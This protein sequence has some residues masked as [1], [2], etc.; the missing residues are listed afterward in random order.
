MYK[1]FMYEA[2]NAAPVGYAIEAILTQSDMDQLMNGGK[3]IKT[4]AAWKNIENETISIKIK[5]LTIQVGADTQTMV[6]NDEVTLTI[7]QEMANSVVTN[8]KTGGTVS[9]AITGITVNFIK[10]ND[11]IQIKKQNESQMTKLLTFNQFVNEA[12]G[13]NWIVDVVGD[14]KKG[15]LKKEMGGKVTAEKIAKSEAELA[16][17]DKDK[18]KPGLQLDAKDAKKHKR[19]VLAKNLMAT[20]KK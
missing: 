4:D 3:I 19:N 11:D 2:V 17:K 1:N 6:L 14:M 13:K 8:I 12:K 15:A 20:Q 5:T 18:K 10:S 16:K 7:T 9:E